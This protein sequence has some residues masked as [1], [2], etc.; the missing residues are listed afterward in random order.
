M[1]DMVGVLDR[2]KNGFRVVLKLEMIGRS[3]AV[4]VD[5]GNIESVDRISS[6][7]ITRLR[8]PG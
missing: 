4:E 3:V 6:G 8:F 5:V 2:T 1:A 7:A